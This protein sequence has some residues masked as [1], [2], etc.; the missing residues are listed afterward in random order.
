MPKQLVKSNPLTSRKVYNRW[1]VDF[2]A[3]K[4]GCLTILSSAIQIDLDRLISDFVLTL[5]IQQNINRT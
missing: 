4:V 2:Q 3:K 1:I 5:I